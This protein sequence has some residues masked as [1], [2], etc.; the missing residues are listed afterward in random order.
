[1]T[2]TTPS[3]ETSERSEFVESGAHA[4]VGFPVE[5]PCRRKAPWLIVV[6]AVLI[7]AGVGLA[8]ADPLVS[9]GSGRSGA[10]DNSYPTSLQT[11]EEESISQQTSVDATLGY[12]GSYSVVNQ[13]QGMITW[14]P[15]T[16]QVI[17]DGQVLYRV[18][19]LPVVL[20]YGSTPAYRT[21]AEGASAA[22]V[23]GWDV[24]ELNADLVALGYANGSE[25]P[26]GSDDF[27]WWTQQAV[28]KLQA[29]VGVTQTGALALGGV[30]FLP[31]A[32]RITDV[33]ATLGGPAGP[34]QTILRGTSTTR[35][36]T[37]ALDA[38]QQSEVQ[39][40]DHVIIT[41]PNNLTTPGRVSSV[42]TVATAPSGGGANSSPTI[43][44]EVSPSDPA[45]TGRVD[46]A[47]V[48]VSITTATINDALVVPVN[49]LIALSSG[50]Y[51]VEVVNP[52]GVRRLVDVTLGIFDN[53]DGVVQVHGPG[54]GAGQHVVVPTA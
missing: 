39:A 54:L 27:S 13:A 42:G 34:G 53:A 14:L 49:A 45:A 15:T 6:A 31:S 47:P 35:E 12:A 8:V 44:V 28:E 46:Q 22:A 4:L 26:A 48:E 37:I 20:L 3:S 5:G 52:D 1:M 23:T 32:A 40:G 17:G 51:A 7:T 33:S 29:A 10:T 19:G 21:L 11:V 9:K 43:M 38:A 16:G 30:V 24:A 50:G 18:D 36:V 2:D 41:L 25:I